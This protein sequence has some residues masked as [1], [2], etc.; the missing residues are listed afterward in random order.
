MDAANI[1]HIGHFSLETKRVAIELWKAKVPLKSI[2][3]QL[4][5]SESTL[6]RILAFAKKNPT[7][8]VKK[9]K[10]G[11]GRKST[12]TPA[13]IQTMKNILKSNP[14]VTAR[15]LKL[16][17][18]GLQHIGI[19]QIQRICLKSLKLPSRKMACKPLLSQQMRDK[20]VAFAM[21]YRHWTVDDWKLVMFSDES[22]F[23]LN[24]GSR[25]QCCRRPQGSDRFAPQFTKKTVKHPPKIMAWGSFSWRGRGGLEF[26][27][28]GEMM[29]GIRYRKI[30]EDKLE[31]FMGQ[32]GCTHFLQ[33]GAPCHKSKLVTSWF[34]ERPAIQLIDWPGN[35]PDLNPIENVWSW[36]KQQ[37]RDSTATSLPDLQKE[38][39]ELWTMKMDDI[40][41]LKALVE[42]MPRRIEDVIRR[43][44]N[45]TKY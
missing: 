33:D 40:P 26:L 9:R 11:T 44:G 39:T 12:I 10:T 30:L 35:S 17:V 21:T 23:E 41:Y 4:S 34:R 16:R 8:P 3:A 25:Q 14:T 19:H 36:M 1:G 20:R 18:Q 43:D 27:K 28:Q 45:T 13:T 31:F 38:I 6:R 29:N 7:L 22:H 37:L 15:G 24:P 2:R 42:S 5:M 32:H